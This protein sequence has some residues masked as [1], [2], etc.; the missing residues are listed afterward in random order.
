M[1]TVLS[2]LILSHRYRYAV[3]NTSVAFLTGIVGGFLLACALI[4]MVFHHGVEESRLRFWLSGC[5]AAGLVG[6]MVIYQS[7]LPHG[8]CWEWF[9]C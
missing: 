3:D 9:G 6:G 1:T 4:W 8:L 5:A 7:M 2:W